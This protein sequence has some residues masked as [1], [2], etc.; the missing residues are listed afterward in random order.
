[1]AHLTLETKERFRS[2]AARRNKSMSALVSE[3]IEDWLQTAADED[4]GEVR[5]NKRGEIRLVKDAFEKVMDPLRDVPL[6]LDK[7]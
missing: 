4:V 1:M 3:V 7:E 5:S 6:P 2:E